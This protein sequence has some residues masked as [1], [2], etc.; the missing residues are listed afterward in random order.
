MVYY[1]DWVVFHPLFTANN[2]GVGHC[3][4]DTQTSGTQLLRGKSL[5]KNPLLHFSMLIIGNDFLPRI[6][7]SMTPEVCQCYFFFYS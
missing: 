4:L 6:G 5:S 3:S 2:Q 1:S 7:D